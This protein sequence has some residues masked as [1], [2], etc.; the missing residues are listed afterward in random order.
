MFNNIFLLLR[1]EFSEVIVVEMVKISLTV[2]D[3]MGVG[4]GSMH[5]VKNHN[6]LFSQSH[7]RLCNTTNQM[8]RSLPSTH[9]LHGCW[10]STDAPWGYR[11]GAGSRFLAWKAYP[12]H[13]HMYSQHH[14]KAQGSDN[15]PTLGLE[16]L[17]LPRH[18]NFDQN[19]MKKHTNALFEKLKFFVF[20]FLLLVSLYT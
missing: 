9:S 13:T 16:H 17:S 18:D 20:N 3:A 19:C 1:L 12:F 5:V 2:R 8:S 10:V 11:G 15:L 4:K 14:S 7:A 6:G